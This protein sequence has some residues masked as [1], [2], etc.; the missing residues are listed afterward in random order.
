M[1]KWRAW[2]PWSVDTSPAHVEHRAGATGRRAP[3][4]QRKDHELATWDDLAREAPDLAREGTELMNRD[5]ILMAQLA[6]VRGD[7]LPRINPI[8][9]GIV[10]GRLYSFIRKS[11]KRDDLEADGR[12]ALHSH[13]DAEH[14]SDFSMRGRARPV[15]D[16]GVVRAVTAA[17]YFEPDEAYRLFE[18]SIEVA[19]LGRRASAQEM[20]RHAS[21]R[22]ATAGP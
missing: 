11:H 12:Y 21:W 16:P 8:W 14:V 10:N 15:D 2:R 1:R 3:H 13:Q 5:G 7:D 20:P 4:Q 6:T 9:I 19:L 22:A 18:F 17:W